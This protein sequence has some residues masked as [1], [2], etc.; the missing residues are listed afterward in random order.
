MTH[1]VTL[2]NHS[3]QGNQRSVDATVNIT[4]YTTGGEDLS[5]LTAMLPKVDNLTAMAIGSTYTFVFTYVPATSKLYAVVCNTGSQ[6][7]STWNI[8]NVM[9]RITG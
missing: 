9:V 6:V 4:S 7:A 2:V 3:V 5:D 8:G 1:T